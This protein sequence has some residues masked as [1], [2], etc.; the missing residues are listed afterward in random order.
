VSQSKAR[1]RAVASSLAGSLL[2]VGLATLTSAPQ[3]GAA[4]GALAATTGSTCAGTTPPVA[5]PSG[6]WTC[7]FDDEF[8]GTALDTT[9][10]Q[11]TLSSTSSYRAGPMGTRVCYENDPR[12]LSESGGSLNLSVVAAAKSFTC[13]G[14]K[15]SFN[16]RYIGGMVDSMGLF[17]QQYG[18]FQVRAKLPPQTVPGVQETLW[19]Y[20]ENETLYGPWPDSGEIDFGEF[21]SKYPNND[22]P[23]VHFPGSKQDPNATNNYCTITGVSTAGQWNTYSVMWTPTTITTYFNGVTCFADNYW[24]Y[25]TYPDKAPEP[26][27]QPF[28]I[29][30]TQ[31]LGIYPNTFHSWTTPL[32]ATTNIDYVRVWQY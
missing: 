6:Q 13:K 25:V 23:V 7:T 20:P 17:S 1:L 18:Y 4:E 26:F 24:K 31:T 32:P 22:I 15:Q 10:W 2:L 27:T 9:L 29:N 11:P 14:I 12:T 8:N 28:F 30:L 3:A 19:L 21:Y 5:P 16:T